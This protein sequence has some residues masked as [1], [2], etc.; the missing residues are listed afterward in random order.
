MTAN[1]ACAAVEA[2][3]FR[4]KSADVFEAIVDYIVQLTFGLFALVGFFLK[5]GLHKSQCARR[6]QIFLLVLFVLSAGGSLICTYM[7]RIGAMASLGSGE[8]QYEEVSSYLSGGAWLTLTSGLLGI[9]FVGTTLSSS[10]KT[11]K[12][13]GSDLDK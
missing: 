10:S 4:L 2:G 7:S 11:P 9:A 6:I 8:F 13:S 5:D 1:V 12:G 3:D